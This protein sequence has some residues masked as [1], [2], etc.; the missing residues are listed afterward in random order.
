MNYRAFLSY[1]HRDARFADRFHAKLEKWRVDRDLVGRETPI[2]P[3]PQ[4][5]RPVFRDREDFAGGGT[6]PEAISHALSQS[7]FLVVLCSPNAAQ[8]EY[9]NEEIRLFKAMGRAERII[10]LI[11]AGE[12]GSPTDECFPPALTYHVDTSGELTEEILEPLAADAR[13]E[14]D[15]QPRATAKVVAGLLGLPFDVIAKRADRARRVRTRI[16]GAVATVMFVLAVT[17]GGFAWLSETRRVEADH[18]YR[19]ALS[20]AESLLGEVG[21]ELIRVDGIQLATTKRVIDRATAVLDGLSESL[22]D[23]IELK[24]SRISALVVFGQALHAKG[25]AQGAIAR[26]REAESL[27]EAVAAIDPNDSA[28]M[29]LLAMIHWRLG[30]TLGADE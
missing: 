14:G 2:G 9:V 22:P 6:L 13:E 28:G 7:Q 8:S 15:G 26:Y 29:Q 30:A 24:A 18:N 25:D 27:A 19:A 11:I 23:S 20:A 21:E 3:V 5:L 10:P 16:L 4:T 12:P 17:S 1:S